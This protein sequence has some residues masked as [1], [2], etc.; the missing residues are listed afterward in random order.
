MK[1]Q[2]LEKFCF[3]TLN[4]NFKWTTTIPQFIIFETQ[5]TPIDKKEMTERTRLDRSSSS[6]LERA[7]MAPIDLK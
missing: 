2:S 1:V 4:D 6:N 3:N 5:T 7:L